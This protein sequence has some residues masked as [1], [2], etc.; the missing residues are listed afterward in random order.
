MDN[1]TI[2]YIFENPGRGRQSRNFTTNVSKILDLK[3]SSEQISPEIDVGCPWRHSEHKASHFYFV[4]KWNSGRMYRVFSYILSR[5]ANSKSNEVPQSHVCL[6]SSKDLTGRPVS[7]VL[8][9]FWA[10]F[11]VW[12]HRNISLRF[13]QPWV[14]L[15]FLSIFWAKCRFEEHIKHEKLTIW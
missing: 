10:T 9:N 12:A 14:T 5:L 6:W 13:W 11:C 1:Y 3:L 7:I 2:F 8:S 4:K 15:A